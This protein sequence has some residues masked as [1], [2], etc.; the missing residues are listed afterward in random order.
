MRSTEMAG[1]AGIASPGPAP[2]VGD[3]I[4]VSVA[5]EVAMIFDL[6][7]GFAA[8]LAASRLGGEGEGKDGARPGA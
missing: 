7:M 1:P 4:A 3:G 5:G 6:R 2:V 8:L